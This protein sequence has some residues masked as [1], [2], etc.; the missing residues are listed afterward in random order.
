MKIKTPLAFKN[1]QQ[2]MLGKKIDIV[3]ITMEGEK[4][5]YADRQPTE[6]NKNKHHRK[7]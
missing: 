6:P 4:M 5:P 2:R 3:H 1:T 7:A